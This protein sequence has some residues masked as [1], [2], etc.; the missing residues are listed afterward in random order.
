MTDG[1]DSALPRLDA[2]IAFVLA[3]LAPFGAMWVVSAIP[4]V[5]SLRGKEQMFIWWAF[6]AAALFFVGVAFGV[7]RRREGTAGV[8]LRA[9][10]LLPALYSAAWIFGFIL[11]A[12]VQRNWDSMSGHTGPGY[13]MEGAFLGAPVGAAFA[14]LVAI[15]S[16][17]AISRRRALTLGALSAIPAL[18]LLAAWTT[19]ATYSVHGGAPAYRVIAGEAVAVL[20]LATASG[21]VAAP[22]LVLLTMPSDRS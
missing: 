15:R 3:S 11:L 16:S 19:A 20:L 21:V 14:A 22:L 13:A 18:V 6:E 17:H 2:A 7:V 12:I 10:F 9:I 4:A 1:P 5:S 8:R